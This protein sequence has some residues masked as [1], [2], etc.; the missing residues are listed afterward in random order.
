MAHALII[1]GGIAGPVTAMALQ[2]AGITATV[3]EAYPEGAVEEAGSFLALFANGLAALRTLGCLGP[4]E[5]ASSAADTIESYSDTGVRLGRQALAGSWDEGLGVRTLPRAVLCRTLRAEAVR[6]GIPFRYGKRLTGTAV[7]PDGTITAS[8]A[9]GTHA[10]GDFLV[11]ADGIHSRTRVLLDPAAPP[12]RHTGQFTVCGATRHTGHPA[13]PRTYRMHYGRRAFFGCTTTPGGVT[14]WFANIPGADLPRDVL[15]AV[16]ADEWR[17]RVTEAFAED[18]VPAAA[19]VA[20]TGDEIT[21]LNGYDIP[22]TRVWHDAHHV[23]AGDAAHAT[24]PNAA[25]G[26]SMAIE[27]G[28]VLA[29]CLRDLPGPRQAFAAYERLRRER[30]EKVVAMSAAMARREPLGPGERR[31]RDAEVARRMAG[32][33]RRDTEW[34]TGYR[35]DW[36]APV[37]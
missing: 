14:Y 8:F 11:G 33:P 17:R 10:E 31:A 15:A 12:P 5:E 26:A 34:L 16:T 32:D 3:H 4:V 30:V 24:A 36:D 19:I 28:V 18:A 23:L 6:R 9:D 1:G 29:R 7:R 13:P 25:Q 2:R 37:R 35:V 21:G 20:A 27:D 22:T